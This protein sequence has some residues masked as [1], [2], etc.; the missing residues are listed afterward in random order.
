MV[1]GIGGRKIH[2]EWGLF[3]RIWF[4]LLFSQFFYKKATK[5]LPKK[6]FCGGYSHI[7]Y[8]FHVRFADILLDSTH[9]SG[10]RIQLL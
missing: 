3:S 2:W 4:F 8:L 9:T 6:L 10:P 7:S 1:G 5:I